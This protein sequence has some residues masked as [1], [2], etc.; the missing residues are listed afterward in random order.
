METVTIAK[1]GYEKLKR[2]EK[3]DKELLQD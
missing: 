1:E 3:A 2:A